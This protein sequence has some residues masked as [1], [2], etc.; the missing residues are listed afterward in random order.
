[1]SNF[2]KGGLKVTI[3][4]ADRL[5]Q[6]AV[7]EKMCNRCKRVQPR[8][9][10]TIDRSAKDGLSYYCRECQS[11]YGKKKTRERREA[12]AKLNGHT[13]ELDIGETA[14]R[15]RKAHP[16]PPAVV[17]KR[18]QTN[19]T[20]EVLAM[21]SMLLEMPREDAEAVIRMVAAYYGVQ[22]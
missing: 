11:E 18:V 20:Q 15:W 19:R 6:E 1:M 12:A 3:D 7:P 21:V 8:T 22:P 2:P 4:D 14:S 9:A 10:F 5:V 17:E 13:G 16:T